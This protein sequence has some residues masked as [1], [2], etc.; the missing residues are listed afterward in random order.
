MTVDAS[1]AGGG[2][3]SIT[4]AADGKQLQTYT[5]TCD[6]TYPKPC[7]SSTA[8]QTFTLPTSQLQD[9]PHTLTLTAIDAAGNETTASE[10]IMT[11]NNPPPAPAQLA[12]TPPAAGGYTFTA[13]WQAP[14]EQVVP[15]TG[16]L[17]QLC[18]TSGIGSCT[19]PSTAPIE[20][21]ATITAPSEGT[22]T[23]EVWYTNAA[24]LGGSSHAAAITFDTP[25]I[26]SGALGGSGPSF[27]PTP[28]GT[29]PDK[30]ADSLPPPHTLTLHVKA[31]IRG[32]RVLVKLAGLPDTKVKLFYTAGYRTRTTAHAK[33]AIKL[34]TH[35]QGTASF[36]IPARWA[37]IQITARPANSQT[38]TRT[39]LHLPAAA[40]VRDITLCPRRPYRRASKD[41]WRAS[42]GARQHFPLAAQSRHR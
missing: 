8:P 7:P 33:A 16:A 31:N 36:A 3:Q 35:G 24:G 1:D 5:A 6:F 13:S 26:A 18:R 41:R 22:W 27:Q 28:P 38:V 34:D 40:L 23:L 25:A 37:N 30:N 39:T 20:G 9:G 42:R 4:L 12:I 29:R 10:Q 14:D 2:L 19:T 17:Y 15:I 21:P 32:R 11:A